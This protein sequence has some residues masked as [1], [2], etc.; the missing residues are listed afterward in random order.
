MCFVCSRI[1]LLF[2]YCIRHLPFRIPNVD[3]V[4]DCLGKGSFLPVFVAALA[5]MTMPVDIKQ[6]R[7]LL[8]GT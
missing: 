1:I 6:L 7:S 4:L 3:D 5:N 2:T 8:G